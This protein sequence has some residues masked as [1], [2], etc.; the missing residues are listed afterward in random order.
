V[1][2]IETVLAIVMVFLSVLLM[3]S[4]K[5]LMATWSELTVDEIIYHMVAPLQG[6]STAMVR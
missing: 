6:T 2:D 5:W 4:V 3:L 1:I